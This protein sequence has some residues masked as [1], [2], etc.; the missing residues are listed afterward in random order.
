MVQLVE[1]HHHLRSLLSYLTAFIHTLLYFDAC[2]HWLAFVVSDFSLH[3]PKP[4]CSV[5][6]K[7]TPVGQFILLIL[8]GKVQCTFVIPLQSSYGRELSTECT[9]IILS[10]K[11]LSYLLPYPTSALSMSLM[12]W[13]C[14]RIWKKVQNSSDSW[15]ERGGRCLEYGCGRIR[16]LS[17]TWL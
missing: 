6:T 16:F 7:D 13:E 11:L 5:I 15:W 10:P 17:L 1:W 8:G 9:F 4:M 14:R 2:E 3:L 12:N